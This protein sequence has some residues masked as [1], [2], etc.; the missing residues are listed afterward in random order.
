[1]HS[2][3]QSKVQVNPNDETRRFQ[4]KEL[5]ISVN[6]R[7]IEDNEEIHRR[8]YPSTG[9]ETMIIDWFEFS[10]HSE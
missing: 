3:I 1:M 2:L 7:R 6:V 10:S 9:I 5:G 8:N 4:S